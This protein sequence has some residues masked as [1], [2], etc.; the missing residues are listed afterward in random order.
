MYDLSPAADIVRSGQK[1]THAIQQLRDI[2]YSVLYNIIGSTRCNKFDTEIDLLS[3][4]IYYGVTTL[5]NNKTLGEEYCDLLLAKSIHNN[6]YTNN[7]NNNNS[8]SEVHT[9]TNTPSR[10]PTVNISSTNSQTVALPGLSTPQLQS[11]TPNST[12]SNSNTTTKPANSTVAYKLLTRNHVRLYVCIRVLLPYM[13]SKLRVRSRSINCDNVR[14]KLL[15]ALY[16]TYNNVLQLIIRSDNLLLNLGKFHLALFY[17]Y[18][19]YIDIYKRICGIKY[20]IV[21]QLDMD[22]P[23]YALLGIIIL[24]QLSMQTLYTAVQYTTQ[25]TQQW[26]NNTLELESLNSHDTNDLHPTILNDSIE[27]NDN[28]LSDTDSTTASCSLCLSS[29]D[30]STTTTECG[31]LYHW[32]CIAEAVNNVPA[33]PLC[34][35]PCAPQQLIMLAHYI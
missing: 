15:W 19:N 34:R 6:T 33:C 2:I 8:N 35:Q 32:S 20:V 12:T 10:V 22:R 29:L 28:M 16:K 14:N 24:A 9:T 26:N 27:L 1:D 23:S 18:G 21:R 17:V 25:Q 11:A 13:Y 31:H 4:T 3:N 5:Q 7:K 30:S